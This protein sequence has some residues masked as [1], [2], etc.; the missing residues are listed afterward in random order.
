MGLGEAG[1]QRCS[2]RLFR[3]LLPLA[4]SSGR[5]GTKGERVLDDL[6]A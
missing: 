3:A 4:C 5:G 1:R 2:S 6:D